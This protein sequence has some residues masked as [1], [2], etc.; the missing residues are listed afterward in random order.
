MD[1]TPKKQTKASLLRHLNNQL[2]ELTG[3]SL[4]D[5]LEKSKEIITIEDGIYCSRNGEGSVHEKILNVEYDIW[6]AMGWYTVD[7]IPKVEYAYLS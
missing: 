4:T 6:L 7:K 5:W 1:G 2:A 3:L